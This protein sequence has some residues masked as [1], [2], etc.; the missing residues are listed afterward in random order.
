VDSLVR[1]RQRSSIGWLVVALLLLS[2]ALTLLQLGISQSYGQLGSQTTQPPGQPGTHIIQSPGPPQPP[3]NQTVHT[4]TGPPGLPGSQTT[5]TQTGPPG[6]P[7]NQ[8]RRGR[9]GVPPGL[10]NGWAHSNVT[11]GARNI[12]QPFFMNGTDRVRLSHIAINASSGGQII[13]NIAF[14]QTV[15]QVEFDR[16]GSIQLIIN[17]SVKPTQVFA[18]NIELSEAQ[19]L[20]GLTPASEMW[21]YDQ[22]KQTL[23]IFADPSCITLFYG[24]VV[25]PIPE[26][27]AAPALVLVISLVTSGL[28][29]NRQKAC[30]YSRKEHADFVS[31]ISIDGRNPFQDAISSK[32]CLTQVLVPYLT[33]FPISRRRTVRS[34]FRPVSNFL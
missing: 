7:T 28:I 30:R 34:I 20:N 33:C 25:S 31:T 26:F 1:K 9:S 17:S 3:G 6:L 18:D 29:T 23:M 16:N 5:R 32:S 14:N 22:N 13:R 27:P 21:F 10:V 15:A 12:T 8:T 24:P 19:S 2:S 4:Q 11:V